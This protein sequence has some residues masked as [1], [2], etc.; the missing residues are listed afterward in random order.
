VFKINKDGNELPILKIT[1]NETNNS[2]LLKVD[3]EFMK[4]L[5]NIS[6]TSDQ[7]IIDI[8]NA[9]IVIGTEEFLKQVGLLGV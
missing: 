1:V 2:I 9:L 7:E 4:F 6:N 8:L 3:K 5:K